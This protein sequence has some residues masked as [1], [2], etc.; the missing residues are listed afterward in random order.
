M[1]AFAQIRRS[2]TL[3]TKGT[4]LPDAFTVGT[5]ASYA[6]ILEKKRS[7][8]S[9]AQVRDARRLARQEAAIARAR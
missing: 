4:P 3:A 7:E 1:S 6:R 2:T 5:S 9:A 8:R